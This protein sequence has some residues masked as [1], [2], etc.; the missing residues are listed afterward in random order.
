MTELELITQCRQQNRAAQK[1]LFERFSP[2]MLGVCR[3]Y[4]RSAEDA[5]D[6]MVEG[7]FK[8]MTNLEKY[9][10]TGS[11]EGWV[12]RIV[13]NEALMFLRKKHTFELSLEDA[14]LANTLRSED[15]TLGA[16]HVKEILRLVEILP[17]GY[18][19]V[20]NLYVIEGYKHHEI[21][22]LLNIS[23]STSKSQLM[24]A[25]NRLQE[26]IKKTQL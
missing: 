19:T 1:L 26:F 12:R 23:I 17:V 9:Q 3:R 20:F 15:D 6:V 25:K 16:L 14:V 2:K 11:F 22:E 18:K 5:E 13:V 24:M 8:A 7:L 4:L 21:A 10:A